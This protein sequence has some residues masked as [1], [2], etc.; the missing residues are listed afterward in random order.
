MMC[1]AQKVALATPAENDMVERRVLQPHVSD[2]E[3]PT[4]DPEEAKR[5]AAKAELL[6]AQAHLCTAHKEFQGHRNLTEEEIPQL[7][8]TITEDDIGL[9]LQM[10]LMRTTRNYIEAQ[11]RV[12]TA[13]AEGRRLGV[14]GVDKYP[15][16]QTWN[17]G[18]RPD[19]GYAESIIAD[20]VEKSKPRVKA[21]LSQL[22]K[23]G[24]PLSP[25][26][27]A[28]APKKVPGKFHELVELRLGDDKAED[29]SSD[30]AKERIARYQKACEDLRN[31]G[32]YP[33]AVPDR[34]TSRERLG[35][36]DSHMV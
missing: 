21:W 32:Q 5:D 10:K 35:E 17:F 24:T 23:S 2:G 20:K 16:D 27:K 13:Q 6:P 36:L 9:E 14:P 7:P 26:A 15:I 1:S 33:L 11:E 4:A 28:Q 22:A 30:G 19:D 34:F 18:D 29:S 31:C 25:S 12:R 3:E 8:K